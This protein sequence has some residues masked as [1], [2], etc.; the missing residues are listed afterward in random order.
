MNMEMILKI[1]E[2]NAELYTEATA[3]FASLKEMMFS[4]Q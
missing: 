3:L 2:N 4:L 1:F